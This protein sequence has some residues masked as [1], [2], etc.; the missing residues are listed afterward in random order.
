M[1]APSIILVVVALSAPAWPW[2][3]GR[4]GAS[5][6]KAAVVA[7]WFDIIAAVVLTPVVTPDWSWLHML[8]VFSTC[9]LAAVVSMIVLTRVSKRP[10]R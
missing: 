3:A 4:L 9:A 1:N 8:P 10:P 2:A 5:R 7:V 6:Q